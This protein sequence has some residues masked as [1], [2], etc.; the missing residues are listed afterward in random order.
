MGLV[1][2]YPEGGSS[3]CLQNRDTYIGRTSLR[4]VIYRK[5]GKVLKK[6]H[7]LRQRSCCLRDVTVRTN[8]GRRTAE[9]CFTPLCYTARIFFP[10]QHPRLKNAILGKMYKKKKKAIKVLLFRESAFPY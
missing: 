10:F 8:V 7:F 9:I 4:V 1:Q 2:G 5:N 3:T 6:C